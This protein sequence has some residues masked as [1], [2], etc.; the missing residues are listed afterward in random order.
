MESSTKALDCLG[1]SP[2]ESWEDI[3]RHLDGLVGITTR[4][5]LDLSEDCDSIGFV[6]FE[7][8]VDGV[9]LEIAKYASA[10]EGHFER[11]GRRPTI[12]CIGGDFT[13]SVDYVLASRWRRQTLPGANGWKK[14]KSG[15]WFDALF[16]TDLPEGSEHSNAVAAEI[17]RQAM[18]HA[19]LLVRYVVDQKIDWII[20][21]NVNSNPG[22]PG[23]ALG[24][25]L[26]TEL[27]G[28]AVVNSNHDFYW[29]SGMP[30]DER[31][32]SG[33]PPGPRDH[34]FRN[35]R[36]QSFF[37]LLQRL[38]PW[39]G[40]RW[41]QLVI[42][43]H[44]AETLVNECGFD[45]TRVLELGTF[46]EDSY[47]EPSAL[48]RR[49]ECRR[50]LARI[51]GGG[52]EESRV[53]PVEEFR[54]GVPVWM[55]DQSPVVC[56]LEEGLSLDP[57]SSSAI[58][59]LQPTRVVPRK[60]IERDWDLIGALFRYPP[61]RTMF[62]E[63]EERTLTLH[64]TGPIPVEHEEDLVRVLDAYRGVLSE[65]PPSLARRVF[66]VFT[67]GKVGQTLRPVNGPPH[68]TVSDLYVLSDLALLP[69]Q[70]EGR[71]LPILESAAAGVP[72]VCSRYEPHGVFGKV[73]GESL[74]PEKQI[75]YSLFPEG[76]FETGLLQEI[77]DLL[78]LPEWAGERRRHNRRAVAARYSMRDLTFTFETALTRLLELGE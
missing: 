31:E 62:E 61:F 35:H 74:E 25:V 53:R 27:T 26:A 49:A 32:R 14:W 46:V 68:L 36:N 10:L 41:M 3:H 37:R 77:T 12:H 4:P 42:N 24:I 51:L 5:L 65:L 44:Q 64:V 33:E 13:P 7:Y 43:S 22:N 34:F 28:V 67:A 60:R 40:P 29:E 6:T 47:F 72:L 38:C 16:H 23:V 50:Q 69:S 21:V 78:F 9:S 8:G 55:D 57:S 48:R 70:T 20:P 63:N 39:N 52:E 73:V 66:Q 2:V 1:R 54:A 45:A 75:L 17:W 30:A 11:R 18:A 19:D 58:W 15:K 56:G 71:G 76:R 59:L